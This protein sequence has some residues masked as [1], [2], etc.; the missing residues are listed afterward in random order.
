MNFQF[1]VPDFTS[2]IA[3]DKEEG[4]GSK[5]SGERGITSDQYK[6]HQSSHPPRVSH[7]L[8]EVCEYVSCFKE[9]FELLEETDFLSDEL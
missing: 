8:C 7:V 9:D 3:K 2:T 4:V 6:K 5:I 1:I